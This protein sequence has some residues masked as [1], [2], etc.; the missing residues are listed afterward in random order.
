MAGRAGAKPGRTQPKSGKRADPA[1]EGEK[2]LIKM[3]MEEVVVA[4][5]EAEGRRRPGTGKR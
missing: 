4:E 3:G 2:R 1:A 5:H